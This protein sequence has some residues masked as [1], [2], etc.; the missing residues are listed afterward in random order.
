MTEQSNVLP[1][2]QKPQAPKVVGKAMFTVNVN[3]AEYFVEK[4][5]IP[6]T[7]H[8]FGKV[9][10]DNGKLIMMYP[11]STIPDAFVGRMIMAYRTGYSEGLH[12]GTG[13]AA[14]LKEGA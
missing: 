6:E 7:G 9:V 12:N 3:D 1:F 13:V 14:K 2:R 10:D 4:A 11:T 5:F 8:G